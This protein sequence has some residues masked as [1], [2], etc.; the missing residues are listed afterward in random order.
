MY[1]AFLGNGYLLEGNSDALACVRRRLRLYGLPQRRRSI[2]VQRFYACKRYSNLEIRLEFNGVRV[3]LVEVSNVVH[4]DGHGIQ[5][6]KAYEILAPCVS[7]P[8]LT[9][10]MVR[11]HRTRVCRGHVAFRGHDRRKLT[12]QSSRYSRVRVSFASVSQ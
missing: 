3:T 7:V 11:Y 6:P 10:R 2:E 8:F 9:F 12:S 1:A 5:L 4:R